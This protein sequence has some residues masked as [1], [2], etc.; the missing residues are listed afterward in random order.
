M[1]ENP[2]GLYLD[3]F[4]PQKKAKENVSELFWK[5]YSGRQKKKNQLPIGLLGRK[6]EEKGVESMVG[7]GYICEFFS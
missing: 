5:L 1:W 3:F 6:E 2:G 4:P 7:K